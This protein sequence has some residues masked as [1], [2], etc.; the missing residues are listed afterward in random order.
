MHLVMTIPSCRGALHILALIALDEFERPKIG[1]YRDNIPHH[2]AAGVRIPILCSKNTPVMHNVPNIDPN[3]T[4]ISPHS[5]AETSVLIA[6]NFSSSS[7][8]SSSSPFAVRSNRKTRSSR[9]NN[10]DKA[11]TAGSQQ[12]TIELK[13]KL[14]LRSKRIQTIEKAKKISS[15]DNSP[16]NDRQLH[17]LRMVY[18]EITMYPA[19]PW[20]AILA[21][22]IHR[23][24]KQVK[25]WFSNE[26]Q[27]RG[28]GEE[29]TVTSSIGEKIRVRPISRDS[30]S[31]W[32]DE[33]FEEVVMIYH[34]RVL[35]NLR[36]QAGRALSDINSVYDR[37]L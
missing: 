25:N 29:S 31:D 35:C 34:Y 9:K 33:W 23:S 36:W 2:T 14:E 8:S 37:R 3:N 22:I 28:T 12:S 32:S 30:C 27:K 16:A 6:S 4:A 1:T 24:F 11:H 20:I 26:R 21:I 17:V 13:K 10:H 15:L 5:T 18:D 19:E 7:S